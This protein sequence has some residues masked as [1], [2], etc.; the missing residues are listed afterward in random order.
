ML[1]SCLSVLVGLVQ[2]TMFFVVS[3]REFIT[4][5][6]SPVLVKHFYLC[7]LLLVCQVAEMRCLFGFLFT[8]EIGELRC[9]NAVCSCVCVVAESEF[10]S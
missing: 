10:V 9:C 8:H 1:L 6:G 7:E 2:C 3:F 5:V 4:A